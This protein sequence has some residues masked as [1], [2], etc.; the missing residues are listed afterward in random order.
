MVKRYIWAFILFGILLLPSIISCAAAKPAK[1][2]VNK[3]DVAPS[4]IK[5][6]ENV[7]V[8]GEIGNIGGVSDNYT[9]I[10]NV[11][12]KERDR[13]SIYVSPSENATVSFCINETN[14][15]LHQVEIGTIKKDFTVIAKTYLL[16]HD[17]GNFDSFWFRND[18]FGQWIRFD[19]PVVPFQ[20]NKVLIMG[21]RTYFNRPDNKYYTIK[22]WEDDF[23]RELYSKDYPYSKFNNYFDI[24]ENEIDPPVNV[25][26]KFTIEFISHS[27]VDS[28]SAGQDPTGKVIMIRADY[29]S[30]YP[31]NIGISSKGSN[32]IPAFEY[33]FQYGAGLKNG[34]WIIRVEGTQPRSRDAQKETVL[35]NKK[36]N[37]ILKN[38]DGAPTQYWFFGDGGGFWIKYDPPV[39]PFT[40]TKVLIYGY[41]FDYW[42]SGSN[43][44]YYT[45]NIWDGMFQ[46]KLYSTDYPGT[47]FHFNKDGWVIAEINPPIAVNNEFTVEFLSRNESPV[48][49]GGQE[50]SAKIAIGS[51]NK[52]GTQCKIGFS[53]VGYNDTL[54]YLNWTVDYPEIVNSSWMI[55]V[56]GMGK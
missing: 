17:T 1:F 2:V 49:I 9:A 12:G 21:R 11:D 56:E 47:D 39:K 32:N 35:A 42:D 19:P 4:E 15:G 34:S 28:W 45:I 18:P 40:I 5:Q 8:T 29:T 33:M 6:F 23:K 25:S 13:K 51:S 37:Y 54:K 43:A 27:E 24:V 46:K 31:G 50:K 48:W 30:D 16:Q 36:D 26:G 7:T 41:R 44:R 22:I 53:K 52:T 55:R 14:L 10:L 20:V 38:D 3:V